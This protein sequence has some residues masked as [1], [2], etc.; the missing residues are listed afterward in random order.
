M[1]RLTRVA[2]LLVFAAA[3]GASATGAPPRDGGEDAPPVVRDL[4]VDEG[5][6]DL[7][8]R[9]PC[10]RAGATDSCPVPGFPRRPYRLWLPGAQDAPAPVVVA[11]HGGGGNAVAAERGSCAGGD[12]DAPSC[13]HALGAREGFVTVYPNGTESSPEEGAARVWNAGGAAP[14]Q[15]VSG[16]A[17]EEN[18]DD[19]AYVEALLDDL[20]TR[21]AIDPARV[22][23]AGLSN[24]GALVYR[25][26]CELAERIAAVAPIG[27]GNQFETGARC[28][29][30]APVALL[31]VH[32]TADRC[33]EYAGGRAGACTG[34][35]RGLLVSVAR[36]VGGWA[37]RLGCAAEPRLRP[38]PARADD[39]IDVIE[40]V[41]EDCA[42]SLRL[43]TVRGGGHTWVN[44]YQYFPVRVIGPTFADVT[45]E[46]LWDFFAPIRR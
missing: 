31:H 27:A 30:S 21:V 18:V 40:S 16:R 20:A 32:G 19:V 45:N 41:Y 5:P 2:W 8:A 42:A 11:F 44:G 29:P 35:P 4:T 9:R 3:C 13:L 38:G 46:D 12:P 43:L 15:C 14:F 28:A 23:A 25:L 39:G 6:V 1:L 24:G 22:Y 37:E 26:A 10:T 34:N 33:W 36:S 17:C 7:G